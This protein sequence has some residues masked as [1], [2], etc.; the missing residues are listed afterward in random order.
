[1]AL[2]SE[3]RE[4]IKRLKIIGLEIK[5]QDDETVADIYRIG[6]AEGVAFVVH[7]LCQEEGGF[8]LLQRRRLTKQ[9]EK[10][11]IQ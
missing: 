4:I 5:G 8:E 6:V 1:M 3:T 9:R 2:R 10:G 7:E 11:G